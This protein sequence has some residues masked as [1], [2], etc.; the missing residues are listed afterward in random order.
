M[1][2]VPY[3]LQDVY[4]ASA[5][6][7][8]TVISTFAGGGGS[9]TG[10]RLAGGKVLVVN[11]FVEE[12]QETYKENYPE[13]HILPGDIKKLNGKDFLDASGL[14][15]GE[16]DI[17][18]GSPPCSA[19][20][21]AGKLSH[22][23]HEEERIDLFGNVTIE[24]VSG[25]HS[26]GWNQTKNYS[27]GKTVENI[28]DLFFEFLR[29][30]EEIKPK[31]IIAENVK[32]LTIGEAKTYFNKILNTFEEIGYEVV[33]KVL[34][35]R[36]YGVSQTRTRVIFIAIRQDVLSDVG[37][38]FMTLSTL[39]PDPSNIVIPVKD[40]MVGL[41]YDAEEVKY[42]TDKFTNTAYW[43]QTGSKMEIDP[44]KVLTGMDYHPKGHHFNLKR[45]SQYAPAPTLTAMGSADT[46]AGA[47]HW[48]EPRKL[49]LGEL[50]RIMSL[51]DDFK[52][53]GK[54]NQK[55]ERIGRMVPP[56]MMKAIATS[57]YEKV[58]EKYN[59]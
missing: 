50:K 58:L 10:Y 24:K 32:G 54:W 59:G 42:L 26:D 56:L 2:Y 13:T 41:E 3:N 14:K 17:L 28:E 27:D 9:S 37:L 43:K 46:T 36:Y 8:F 47:F 51:P 1:K 39:F 29:V 34:D 12:A 52:L 40:V 20:S 31:V 38:N 23:I 21:V 53:T 6:N 16:V 22:N 49:T 35:S 5:Q 44:P 33:A 48:I 4:D 11:E 45:V 57:V 19:F 18:D 30:A 7:K 25:K 15:V 55:A